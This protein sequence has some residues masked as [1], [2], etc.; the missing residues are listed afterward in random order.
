MIG[1]REFIAGLGSVTAWPVVARAQQTAP[2]VRQI[3]VLTNFP[4]W[5]GRL[6]HQLKAD[7]RILSV[8]RKRLWRQIGLQSVGTPCQDGPA[9]NPLDRGRPLSRLASCAG[10]LTPMSG[11]TGRHLSRAGRAISS[12]TSEF[13]VWISDCG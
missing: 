7:V 4:G 6:P 1:R 9:P 11:R 13:G 3:G 12:G 2:K 8:P 5:L 10:G